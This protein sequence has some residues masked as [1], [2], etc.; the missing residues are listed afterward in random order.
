MLRLVGLAQQVGGLGAFDPEV[1][2]SEIEQRPLVGITRPK[3]DDPAQVERVVASLDDPVDLAPDPANRLVEK[4]LAIL[5]GAPRRAAERLPGDLR[6]RTC[7]AVGQRL[8]TL[9][10]DVDHEPAGARDDRVD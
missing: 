2:T 9:T 10:K 3:L 7:E 5:A 8:T 6:R 1:S 4:R